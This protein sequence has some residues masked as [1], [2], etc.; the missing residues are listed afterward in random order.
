MNFVNTC[1]VL[2]LH[3]V[4]SIDDPVQRSVR[5][6]ILACGCHDGSASSARY[7][8]SVLRA[9]LIVHATRRYEYSACFRGAVLDNQENVYRCLV[10]NSPDRS[11]GR[12]LTTE[13]HFLCGKASNVF[14]VLAK[15]NVMD[16][17]EGGDYVDDFRAIVDK[18]SQAV[19]D[20][21]PGHED[22][23]VLDF[24]W[25]RIKN[26]KGFGGRRNEQGGGMSGF[27]AKNVVYQGM[28]NVMHALG[29]ARGASR[30]FVSGPNP[31][32]LAA[33]YGQREF[34]SRAEQL[35]MYREISNGIESCKLSYGDASGDLKG[36]DFMVLQDNLCKTVEVLQTTTTGRCFGKARKKA[37]ELYAGV[38]RGARRRSGT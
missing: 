32:K 5:S 28:R 16:T 9:V 29:F 24:A 30:M 22:A 12:R 26:W 25:E 4:D 7:L 10:D 15:S 6:N 13:G 37:V 20:F 3:C 35:A 38:P 1:S 34:L 2:S 33:V 19:R 14:M 23:P 21:Q 11:L 8:S 36:V 31:C 18:L 17:L 27:V